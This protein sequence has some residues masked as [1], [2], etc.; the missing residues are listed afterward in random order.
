V[1]ASDYGR[2]MTVGSCASIVAEVNADCPFNPS[3][4][5]YTQNDQTTAATALQTGSGINAYGVL[6]PAKYNPYVLPLNY[7]VTANDAWAGQPFV[8]CF[9]PF[10]DSPATSQFAKP[11]LRDIP[12]YGKGNINQITVLGHQ[13]GSG[14]LS[15]RYQ[16]QVPGP[17]VTDRLFGKLGGKTNGKPNLGANPEDFFDAFLYPPVPAGPFPERTTETGWISRCAP[18]LSSGPP[19]DAPAS[20]TLKK[21]TNDGIPVSFNVAG[22][23]TAAITLEGS[24]A[25]GA[26]SLARVRIRNLSSGR[27]SVGLRLGR[28]AA[29]RVRRTHSHR[30]RVRLRITDGNRST[31][32]KIRPVRLRY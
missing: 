15:D 24:A 16:M 1:I 19:L 21:A 17:N 2:L 4:W 13:T 6:L 26:R 27:H 8:S 12:N 5:Q 11:I 28:R 29:A 10:T 20:V 22:P 31:Q 3:D 7:R 14:Y 30:F 32:T 25:V 9:Y 23:S 18:S